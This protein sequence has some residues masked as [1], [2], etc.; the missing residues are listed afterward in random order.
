MKTTI[1][2]AQI[3]SKEDTI[4]ANLSLTQLG[5]LITPVFLTA[6]IFALLPPF[7]HIAIYKLVL[8]TFFSIPC[9]LLAVRLNGR[10]LIEWAQLALNYNNRPAKYLL[11]IKESYDQLANSD[12]IAEASEP[13]LA[14]EPTEQK[15]FKRLD[16]RE[17]NM[18]RQDLIGKK[19]NYIINKEGV[20]NASFEESK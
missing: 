3:T 11:T 8:I 12:P 1:V 16:P 17:I 9:L 15:V 20:I 10:L 19:I 14:I 13:D 7:M 6:L 18:I 2:P 4:A 5:L